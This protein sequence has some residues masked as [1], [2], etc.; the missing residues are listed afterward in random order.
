MSFDLRRHVKAKQ[1]QSIIPKAARLE[2]F[3]S[4]GSGLRRFISLL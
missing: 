2:L 3:E 1:L 4:E